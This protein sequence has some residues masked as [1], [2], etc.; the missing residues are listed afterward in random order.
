MPENF[1]DVRSVMARY[2]LE[3]HAARADNYFAWMG[4]DASILKKPFNQIAEAVES[5][6][7]L[8]LILRFSE[9]FPGARVMDFGAGTCWLS[10]DLALLGCDVTAV[11]VSAKALAL[12]RRHNERHPFAQDMRISYEVFN[13][14]DLPL[15]DAQFDNIVCFSSFH[16]VADEPAVLAHF[17]RVLRPGGIVAFSEPGPQHSRQPQ[18]QQEMRQ[19]G[20]IERDIDVHA[21][22]R[23]ASA[24]GF[25][26]LRLIRYMPEPDLVSLDSFEAMLAG[27]VSVEFARPYTNVRPFLLYKAGERAADSRMGRGLAGRI[28]AT[29]AHQPDGGIRASVRVTNTGTARWLPSTQA[30]GGVC[31]SS[32]LMDG[33]GIILDPHYATWWVIG[34]ELA[35]NE[36]CDVEIDIPA[37]PRPGLRLSLCFVADRVARF[38][39]ADGAPYILPLDPMAP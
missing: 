5:L 13:G 20:V 18:S 39:G 8:S 21:I 31:I 19:Y 37:P 14:R 27:P 17:H 22:W 24:L 10:R 15:P 2:T 28:Q 33:D 29:L 12:G 4:D 34:R 36:S 9:L 11:D 38:E 25:A 30:W 6:Q 35:S 3:E 1:V 7:A 23:T 26:D 16:H 32:S